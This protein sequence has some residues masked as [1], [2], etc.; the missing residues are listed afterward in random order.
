MG[1]HGDDGNR[2]DKR[3]ERNEDENQCDEEPGGNLEVLPV[4]VLL[5]EDKNKKGEKEKKGDRSGPFHEWILD[6]VKDPRD[7][8]SDECWDHHTEKK[9]ILERFHAVSGLAKRF[10]ENGRILQVRGDVLV[11]LQE[12]VNARNNVAM[13][14][15]F[16]RHRSQLYLE[17]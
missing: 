11:F 4:L 16:N 17:E 12:K 9:S 3:K 15:M 14:I 5:S 7:Q 1:K 6:C 13:E 8:D 10:S 2:S